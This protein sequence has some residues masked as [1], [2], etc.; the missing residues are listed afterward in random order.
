MIYLPK[1]NLLQARL[2]A[3]LLHQDRQQDQ[4]TT[5]DSAGDTTGETVQVVEDEDEVTTIRRPILPD[6]TI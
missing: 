1:C 3:A 6:V 5:A 4:N 2:V